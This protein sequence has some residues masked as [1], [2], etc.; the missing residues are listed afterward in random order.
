MTVEKKCALLNLIQFIDMAFKDKDINEQY[1]DYKAE[2]I[3]SPAVQQHRTGKKEILNKT[4][5]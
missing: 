4:C 5:I 1:R 2:Q 3:K